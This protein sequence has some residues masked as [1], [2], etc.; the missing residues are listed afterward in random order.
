MTQIKSISGYTKTRSAEELD[1]DRYEFITLD[2]TEPNPGNPDSDGAL[3]VS[4]IDGTRSFTSDPLLSGLSFRSLPQYTPQYVLVLDPTSTPG[5]RIDPDRV[6]WST[7]PTLDNDTLYTVTRASRGVG[8]DSTDTYIT[9]Y[10]LNTTTSINVGTDLTVEGN[11]TVNGQQTILNTEIMTVEDRNIV[12][13]QGGA[14]PSAYDS[15]GIIVFGNN[16]SMLYHVSTDTW[17]FNRGL[18][19]DASSRFDG[20]VTVT[21]DLLANSNIVLTSGAAQEIRKD[22]GDLEIFNNNILLKNTLGTTITNFT[23][24]LVDIN[25]K[26]NVA[27]SATFT[28]G[29]FNDLVYL[30]DVPTKEEN[31]RILFRRLTDGLVMEGDV[32][33]AALADLDKVFL[34]PTDSDAIF[35]PLLSYA[36]GGV[37]GNDSAEFDLNLTYQPNTNTLNLI[38]VNATGITD[39]DSTTVEGDFQLKRDDQ[40]TGGRLLDSAGR[41]FVLYDSAGNLLWGNNGISA[42]N[43]GALNY[44]G[45]GGALLYLDDIVDVNLTS[46]IAGQV[47]KYD[48]VNWVN[49]PDQSGAGG[50]GGLLPTD[51]AAITNAPSGTGS[52]TYS[53]ITGVFS[54]TPPFV[55]NSLTQLSNVDASNPGINEV[56]QWNGSSWVPGSASAGSGDPNQNAFSFLS[57]G[58]TTEGANTITDT[59]NF[60]GSGGVAVTVSATNTITIDGSGVGGTGTAIAVTD[61]STALTSGVTSFTFTGAGVTSTAVGNDVTVT[62]PGAA[63]GVLASRD[64]NLAVSVTN[65]P[66]NA[67]TGDPGISDKSLFAYPTYALLKIQTSAA[68]WVRLY[69]DAA[70]RTADTRSIEQDPTPDAGVIAEVITSG[71]QTIKMSPGVIGWCETGSE[72]PVKITNLSGSTANINVIFT[73]LQLEA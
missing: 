67:T 63:S 11:L 20:D 48:G 61:E 26:L 34:K 17:D 36:Q 64:T 9:T 51:L 5:D 2:Q 49:A 50:G 1:A 37:E 3:F 23:S 15:S 44:G 45:P 27:D 7:F 33:I 32:D 56:L 66:D 41:S 8:Y 54:Y 31:T 52:L 18:I 35:Y 55:P 22:A 6:G 10:G 25:T 21:Q 73:L 13:A 59:I 70:S 47:I 46:L 53:D 38:N 24:S 57:D 42:N 39:F 28:G 62:V 19:V 16:A 4:D 29:I 65:I 14:I 68:C 72:V 58:S 40:N 69:V 71:P 60:A 12:V 43:I 30:T